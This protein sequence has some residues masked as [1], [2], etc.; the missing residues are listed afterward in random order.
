MA[1]EAQFSKNQSEV[2]DLCF[3]LYGLDESVRHLLTIGFGSAPSSS[4]SSKNLAANEDDEDDSDESSADPGSLAAALVSW[5]V[6][7]AFGRFDARL[8][9]GAR[10]MPAEPE[11]FDPLPASSLAILTGHDGLP[12]TL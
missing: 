12:L 5:A 8:A 7:V 9:T 2:D 3:A 1:S 10:P 4:E 11:P 6:G